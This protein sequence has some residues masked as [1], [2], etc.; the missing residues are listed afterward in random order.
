MLVREPVHGMQGVLERLAASFLRSRVPFE[1]LGGR[2]EPVASVYECTCANTGHPR[3]KH[4]G[5]P[6]PEGWR[7][8]GQRL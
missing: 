6:K 7:A 4:F 2:T 8:C 3:V 1:N 5:C